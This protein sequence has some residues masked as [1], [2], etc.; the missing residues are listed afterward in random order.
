MDKKYVKVF[1]PATIA[2]VGA[3]FDVLGIALDHPG[4][5]VEATISDAK[6]VFFKLA[7]SP[8][9]VPESAQNVAAYVATC[10]LEELQP[11][12]GVSLILHKQLPVGSGLGSSGAS[13]A[14]AALAV[15]ALLPKPLDRR[16][17]IYFAL[18][19]EKLAAG[20]AHADNVAPALLGG[21]CLI[22]SYQ[23]LDVIQIP[24][25]NS[26]FW[27]VAHP[28]LVLRTADAR[29][30]LPP[31][32]TLSAAVRQC[33]NLG[34]LITGLLLGDHVMVGNAI[35]DEF[36]EPVRASLIPGFQAV[37]SAAIAAGALAFSISGSGPAVFAVTT[38]KEAAAQVATA[39]QEA[40]LH[41]AKVQ[42]DTYVSQINEQ[43]AKILE[44]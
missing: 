2:N 32:V 8:F 17:L 38:D 25:K 19:G 30:V 12:F 29:A 26:L 1:A 5:I 23:P 40:F 24:A 9:V 33:G 13:C 7:E 18:L 34:A 20:A 31:S 11:D 21:V 36:A 27:V 6:G 15:N 22:R 28:H 37:K 10:M 44:E 14:A 4:D 35:H 39:M 3:G 16:E 41:H 42:C 43:G